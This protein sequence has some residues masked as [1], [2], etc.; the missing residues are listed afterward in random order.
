MFRYPQQRKACTALFHCLK[1]LFYNCCG[2]HQRNGKRLIENEYDVC[3]LRS[4][5]SYPWSSIPFATSGSSFSMPSWNKLLLT[6][7]MT[8]LK[9][10][11]GHRNNVVNCIF[12]VYVDWFEQKRKFPRSS[13]IRPVITQCRQNVLTSQLFFWNYYLL[14]IKHILRFRVFRGV[15]RY[16]CYVGLWSLCRVWFTKLCTFV[17]SVLLNSSR[18]NVDLPSTNLPGQPWLPFEPLSPLVPLWPCTERVTGYNYTH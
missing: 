6:D 4:L 2:I 16:L 1:F 3:C 17:E 9:Y 12:V 13:R 11:I 8:F 7:F 10:E 18:N 15:Y 5:Y 14:N